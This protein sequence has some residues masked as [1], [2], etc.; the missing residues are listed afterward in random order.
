MTIDDYSEPS[1]GLGH[2]INY[3]TSLRSNPGPAD[4]FIEGDVITWIII[5]PI[6]GSA[7]F[8]AVF[9]K[10]VWRVTGDDTSY[11]LSKLMSK[12]KPLEPVT[13]TGFRII[14]TWMGTYLNE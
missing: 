6:L 10:G 4:P 12:L 2:K 5:H 3:L 7:H 1:Q 13:V 11:S 14:P 9:S 8:A